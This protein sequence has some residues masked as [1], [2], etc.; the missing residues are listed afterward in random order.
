MLQQ[1]GIVTVYN[2]ALC[3]APHIHGLTHCM[4]ALANWKSEPMVSMISF[5]RV[6]LAS[7]WHCCTKASTL[8]MSEGG[9]ELHR[10]GRGIST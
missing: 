6:T 4:W 3:S 5:P 9:Q 7:S 1:V 8:H 2:A 10:R